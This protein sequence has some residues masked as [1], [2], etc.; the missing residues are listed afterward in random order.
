[1]S[2]KASIKRIP[3]VKSTYTKIQLRKNLTSKFKFE[4]KKKN[5]DNLVIILAGYKEFLWEDVIGRIKKFLPSHNFEVCVVS[6]GLYSSKLSKICK[7]N[8]WSYISVKRNNVCLAQNVA[9]NEFKN[10][11][12]IY[13]LD[14]DMFVTKDY[15]NILKQTYNFVNA[16]TKD[17]CGFVAPVIPINGFGHIKILEHY[18]LEE[19]FV[20]KFGEKLKYSAAKNRQIVKNPN[21]AE[22]FWGNNSTI[23]KIDRINA[24]FHNNKEIYKISP[25]L[26]SIGAILF[27]RRLWE[28]M[29][30]FPV[31]PFKNGMGLDELKL[32]E[33]VF[34]SSRSV[35]VSMRSV[36]GHFGYGPQT[37]EMKKYYALNHSKFE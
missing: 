30:M 2:L 20:Q 12:Y 25:N 3:L 14:E 24:D 13:K 36:V 32:N 29:K 5:T 9:I 35:I 10:A 33:F 34:G 7:Y 26:F 23:P 6:S 15:F 18:G 8:D 19:E 37:D 16:N 27:S 11:K 1:M 21:V 4:G 22:Y 28:E 31:E 17:R